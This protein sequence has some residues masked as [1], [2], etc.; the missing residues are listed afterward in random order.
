VTAI[1][2]PAATSVWYSLFSPTALAPINRT[3]SRQPAQSLPADDYHFQ[4]SLYRSGQGHSRPQRQ[5]GGVHAALSRLSLGLLTKSAD[6][7]K[8]VIGGKSMVDGLPRRSRPQTAMASRAVLLGYPLHPPG[9]LD[10]SEPNICL[11]SKFRC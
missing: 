1:V 8:L 2:Y 11:T 6:K 9:R 3:V 7:T 4:F 5:A 10:G